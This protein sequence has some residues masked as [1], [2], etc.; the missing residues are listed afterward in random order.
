MLFANVI[1]SITI[2][3]FI[4]RYRLLEE[5]IATENINYTWLMVNT[6][7]F[8]RIMRTTFGGL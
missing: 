4:G 2:R 5:R 3:R 1:F 7:I 6:L 8:K